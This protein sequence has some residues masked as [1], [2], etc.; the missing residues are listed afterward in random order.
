[1]RFALVVESV[2]LGHELSLHLAA[3]GH[4]LHV[5][6]S[7]ASLC[8]TLGGATRDPLVHVT[9]GALDMLEFPQPSGC[10]HVDAR[11]VGIED[12]VVAVETAVRDLQPQAAEHL[13]AHAQAILERLRRANTQVS[14]LANAVSRGRFAAPLMPGTLHQALRILK[15]DPIDF[16]VVANVARRDPALAARFMSMA[17]SAYFRRGQETKTIVAAVTR[18]GE[19][20][21]VRL[22]QAVALRAFADQVREPWLADRIQS[23]LA[24]SLLVALVAEVLAAPA[25]RQ[26]AA[27]C[28]TLGLFHNIGEVFMLYA[29]GVTSGAELLPSLLLSDGPSASPK[30]PAGILDSVLRERIAELNAYVVEPMGL[31]PEILE[32]FGNEL[33]LR[34]APAHARIVNQALY[35]AERVSPGA[36]EMVDSG[37][38]VAAIGLAPQDIERVNVRLPE[39]FELIGAVAS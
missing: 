32:L 26:A 25:G 34:D 13:S 28:Y 9:T 23:K 39:I 22:L 21:A 38:D 29:L 18:V 10:A 8:W 37:A 24:R 1:M 31:P 5:A 16:S 12:L 4:A 2:P 35:V 3:R 17:N 19:T 27:E 36:P 14:A 11:S 33:F 15:T 6:Q 30:A 20:A 7:Q